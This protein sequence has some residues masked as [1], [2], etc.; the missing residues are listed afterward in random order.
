[1]RWLVTGAGG[2]LGHDLLTV[3]AERGETDVVATT[4]KD[5]DITDA[6]AVRS[7]TRQGARR[8]DAVDVG[9]DAARW[10]HRCRGSAF[11]DVLRSPQ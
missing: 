11:P 9:I 4:R 8:A 3:L 7:R 1:M 2:M 5:L 10:Y 6:D